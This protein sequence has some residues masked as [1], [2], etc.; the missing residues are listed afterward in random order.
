MHAFA[1]CEK[2]EKGY[3]TKVY[4]FNINQLDLTISLPTKEHGKI[5]KCLPLPC[6]KEEKK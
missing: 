4:V 1:L 2:E 3:L 5:Y 6:V